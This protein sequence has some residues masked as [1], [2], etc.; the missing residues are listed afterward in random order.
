MARGKPARRFVVAAVAMAVGVGGVLGACGGDDGGD[1]IPTYG[2]LAATI[3][4]VVEELRDD[5]VEP[6][7]IVAPLHEG[8]SFGL[9]VQAEVIAML[10]PLFDVQFIDD[11][12]LALV[13]DGEAV[14]GDAILLLLALSDSNR[15]VAQVSG[16]QWLSADE[17]RPFTSRVSKRQ[18]S[19]LATV[20]FS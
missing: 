16:E 17:V 14:E 19:W 3:E 5:E 4:A 15:R 12:D 13:D 7:V 1:T 10:K 6:N 8:T 2:A 11:A 20:T 9:E 18:D